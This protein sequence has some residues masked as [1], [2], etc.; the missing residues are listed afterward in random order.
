MRSQ[1]SLGDVIWYRSAWRAVAYEETHPDYVESHNH[2]LVRRE[3]AWFGQ[4]SEKCSSLFSRCSARRIRRSGVSHDRSD[5]C[6]RVYAVRLEAVCFSAA[7]L[8][9]DTNLDLLLYSTKLPAE[10]LRSSAR[11]A[12]H[13]TTHEASAAHRFGPANVFRIYR[14]RVD[15]FARFWLGF[16]SEVTL[17]DGQG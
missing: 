11:Y 16:R 17:Y 9:K 8:G 3:A 10:S 15:W 5:R 1:S 6:N 7:E 12:R 13:G 2:S 14:A 4:E